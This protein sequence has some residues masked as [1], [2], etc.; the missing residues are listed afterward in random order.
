MIFFLICSALNAQIILLKESERYQKKV[1]EQKVSRKRSSIKRNNNKNLNELLEKQ[2]EVQEKFEKAMERLDNSKQRLQKKSS[3]SFTALSRFRGILLNSVLASNYDTSIGIVKLYPSDDINQETEILCEF[4]SSPSRR[5][6]GNCKKMV[7]DKEYKINA[8]VWDTDG[9][10]G[11]IPDDYYT[12]ETKSFLT[13]TFANF[14]ASVAR[15]AQRTVMT[16]LGNI[17]DN[18]KTSIYNGSIASIASSIGDKAKQKGLERIEIAMLNA[19]KE[20]VIFFNEGV[21]L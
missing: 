11:L 6:I 17:A 13:E 8:Q 19:G 1:I 3:I 18:S 5:A 4:M 16:D 10:S 9:G 20:V 14:I 15:N 12:S 2:K 21:K 7:G